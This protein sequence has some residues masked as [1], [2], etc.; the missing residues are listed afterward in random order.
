MRRMHC[1]GMLS[2]AVQLLAIV[3][4]IPCV[5]ATAA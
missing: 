2:N 3:G 5:S 1:G 4:S